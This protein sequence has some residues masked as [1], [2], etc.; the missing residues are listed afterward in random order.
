[1]SDGGPRRLNISWLAIASLPV[2]GALA[3]L[4]MWILGAPSLAAR[5]AVYGLTIASVVLILY[6][7]DLIG[8]LAHWRLVIDADRNHLP[9]WCQNQVLPFGSLILGLLFG[10]FVW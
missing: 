9:R 10:Y 2:A 6:L 8:R 7:V 3:T 1:M 5:A 4:V